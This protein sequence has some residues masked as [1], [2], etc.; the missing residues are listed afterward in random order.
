[1]GTNKEEIDT[2]GRQVAGETDADEDNAVKV[3]LLV[4]ACTTIT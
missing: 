4:N 2:P 1:V 3:S